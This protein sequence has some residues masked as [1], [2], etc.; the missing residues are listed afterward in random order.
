MKIILLNFQWET[1]HIIAP[2]LIS[3]HFSAKWELFLVFGKVYFIFVN[4][5][6]FFSIFLT[7]HE[8]FFFWKHSRLLVRLAQLVYW[9][10]LILPSSPWWS[11]YRWVV[12]I[13]S[14]K[15]KLI[16]ASVI[17]Q[18]RCSEQRNP[19]NHSAIEIFGILNGR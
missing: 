16:P 11:K 10:R 5:Q 8:F 12:N 14:S 3:D 17:S 7:F 19:L 15:D 4:F 1:F 9:T 13:R 6:I 2:K 18:H